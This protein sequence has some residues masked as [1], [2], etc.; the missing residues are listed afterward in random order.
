M[1]ST[2]TR[3]VFL[4][5]DGVLACYRSLVGDFE[6]DDPSLL[7]DSTSQVSTPLERR[8]L[9]NLKR[10]LVDPDA[11][12]DSSPAAVV[13]T[14][15]WRLVEDQREFLLRALQTEDIEVL[16][17]TPSLPGQGRG[18]EIAAWLAEHPNVTN[19]AILDDDKP[20]HGESFLLA[21]S[22]NLQKH[23]VWTLMGKPGEEEDA[24]RLDG[25]TTAGICDHTVAEVQRLLFLQKSSGLQ[26]S[27]AEKG[28]ALELEPMPELQSDAKPTPNRLQSDAKPTP[29]RPVQIARVVAVEPER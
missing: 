7:F 22:G 24:D 29:N 20:W 28:V 13:L 4:D 23:V 3:V 12:N 9:A 26:E 1:P 2:S 14:T 11:A 21:A 8:C 15:T 18:F 19:Y 27:A 25:S 17:S 6:D 10:S 16:G 5:C